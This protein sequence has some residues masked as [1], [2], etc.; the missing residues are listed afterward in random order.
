MIGIIKIKPARKRVIAVNL[1][2]RAA[3][4]CN[5]KD[6]AM[7]RF[8]AVHTALAAGPNGGAK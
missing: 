6:D 2:A 8:L 1:K 7:A 4:V 5:R 3:I